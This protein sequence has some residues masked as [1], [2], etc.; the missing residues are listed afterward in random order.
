MA[1]MY[2][3]DQKVFYC[4]ETDLKLKRIWQI[5]EGLVKRIHIVIEKGKTMNFYKIENEETKKTDPR[6]FKGE[7]L[8]ESKTSLMSLMAKYG[9]EIKKQH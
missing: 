9:K 3:L 5:K 1:K 8:A 7:C 4:S 6:N 2:N